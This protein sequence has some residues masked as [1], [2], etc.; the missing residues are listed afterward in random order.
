MHNRQWEMPPAASHLRTAL[1]GYRNNV[2]KY[3]FIFSDT[4]AGHRRPLFS[5]QEQKFFVRQP[6]HELDVPVRTFLSE[7]LHPGPVSI[8]LLSIKEPIA[9]SFIRTL[10]TNRNTAAASIQT[11]FFP[12]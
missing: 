11:S 12:E 7:H 4:I 10:S 6:G 8:G 1:R 5:P 3:D 9:G 2:E